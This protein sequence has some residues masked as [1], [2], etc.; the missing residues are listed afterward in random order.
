MSHTSQRKGFTLVELLVVIAIIGILIGLLL[1]AVQAAR[2]AA[3]RM[4]CTNNL[5]QLALAIH[6]YND[7]NNELPG[8]GSGGFGNC[9][10]H[11]GLLSFTEQQARFTDMMAYVGKDPNN[12]YQ[13]PYNRQTWWMGVI[14]GLCCPSDGNSSV[15][16]SDL[17]AGN[18]CFSEADYIYSSYGNWGNTR[19]PFGMQKRRNSYDPW[20]NSSWGAGAYTL[21]AVVDG[22]S[23]TIALS[24]RVSSPNMA[25]SEYKQI[26][27]GFA[28]G[29]SPW[30]NLPNVCFAKRGSGGQYADGVATCGGSNTNLFYYSVNNAFF[31]TIL[32]PNAPSCTS[33]N[34]FGGC[35]YLPPTSNHSGGVNAAMLDGSVRFISE[36][37][38]CETAGTSGL[39]GWYKYWGSASGKSDFGVW[40]ALGTMN[41]GETT[42]L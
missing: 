26:K 18:Y 35:A 38:N 41:C 27:G 36:T 3:R 14:P 16:S 17:I 4:Q 5:K 20:Y 28:N 13:S 6:N 33:D 32:P 39:S 19:S 34:G 25:A 12:E 8:H 11:L 24:E 10:A 21:A 31:Q 30:A 9:T 42:S 22:T 15:S 2:E 23:N 37:I 1:P 40:G 7:V 29:V